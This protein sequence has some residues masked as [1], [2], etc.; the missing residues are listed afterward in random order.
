M[1]D[2]LPELVP[3]VLSR[4][5]AK[6]LLRFR[7]VSKSWRS[8]IDSTAF[9]KLHLRKSMETNSHLNLIF[10]SQDGKIYSS[11]FDSFRDFVR[12]NSPIKSHNFMG[13]EVTLLKFLGSCNGMLCICET[14]DIVALWNPSTRSSRLL[15]CSPI[16]IQ[17]NS[18]KSGHVC[19]G[20]GYDHIKD[21]Y[22]V[23]RMIQQWYSDASFQCE[24]KVFRLST[25]SWKTVDEVPDILQNLKQGYSAFASGA[26]HWLVYDEA[27]FSI[28]AFDLGTEEF[29]QVPLPDFKGKNFDMVIG[30]LGDCLC[31]ICE[32]DVWIMKEYRVKESWINLFSVAEGGVPRSL[33]NLMPLSYSKAYDKVLLQQWK[34]KLVWYDLGAKQPSTVHDISNLRDVTIYVGSL[35]PVTVGREENT[36]KGQSSEGT[37]V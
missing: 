30:S 9:I 6:D 4:L 23:V 31:S 34:E 36:R 22:K 12:L 14:A 10:T 3:D 26:L 20:F 28:V 29:G 8:L 33:E 25:S 21:D 24:F 18:V 5:P 15:P 37:E 13:L 19:Y 35:V 27:E 7:C 16:E 32:S 17:F 2:L 11:N 1:L